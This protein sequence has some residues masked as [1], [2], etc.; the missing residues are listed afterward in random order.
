MSSAEEVL[1]RLVAVG[2]KVEAADGRLVVRAGARP[3]PGELVR[4]LREAK[5]EVLAILSPAWWRHQFVIR[6][7]DRELG[8]ARSH[9]VAAQLAWGELECRWH[10][11]YGER[12]LEWQC[13][14]CGEPMGGLASLDLLD[15]NRVH[16]DHRHGLDC[17]IA[18]GERWRGAATRA[19]A[20]M[21]LKA[22]TDDDVR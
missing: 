21:G 4:R 14:G 19:L 16:L 6:T 20:A 22:P 5:A 12:A 7:I 8:G 11:L 2:A 9:D 17:V 10:R 15:G 3:V 1:D 18:F 13:A